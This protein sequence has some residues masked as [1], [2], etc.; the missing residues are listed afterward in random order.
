MSSSLPL[1]VLSV[2]LLVC[3]RP[4]DE[5]MV[6]GERQRQSLVQSPLVQEERLLEGMKIASDLWRAR[7]NDARL[8]FVDLL[9]RNS[10]VDRRGN[11]L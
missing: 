9:R 3:W 4:M 5:I 2:P 11:M 10:F 8:D 7:E 1:L 6:S